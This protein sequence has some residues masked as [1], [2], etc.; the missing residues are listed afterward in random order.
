MSF[1]SSS[2]LDSSRV[3]AAKVKVTLGPFFTLTAMSGS[4]GPSDGAVD[5]DATA[6]TERGEGSSLQPGS[7]SDARSRT[8]PPPAATKVDKSSIAKSEPL[9]SPSITLQES[10]SA[11]TSPYSSLQYAPRQ[12]P[13]VIKRPSQSSLRSH[14]SLWQQQQQASSNGANIES[15]TPT[16]LSAFPSSS[17]SASSPVVSTLAVEGLPSSEDQQGQNNADQ[18]SA[19]ETLA[20]QQLRA[21]AEELGVRVGSLGWAL[22]EQIYSSP[23][24]EWA[25]LGEMLNR[26]EVT[27]LLP[28]S[29][30][31]SSEITLSHAYNHI[32]FST[33]SSSTSEI[34]TSSFKG[35]EKE[36]ESVTL[37]T[38]KGLRADLVDDTD[39]AESV[40]HF[41]S[42]VPREDM[43]FVSQLR[44]ASKRVEL[45]KTL[46][47]LPSTS[48]QSDTP[49]CFKILAHATG[50][51][52]PPSLAR[53]EPRTVRSRSSSSGPF[54]S[55]EQRQANR[56]S[57]TFATLF[58]GRRE[59]KTSAEDNTELKAESSEEA[60]KGDVI[61]VVQPTRMITVAVIDG[62]I[63]RSQ[64]LK[65]IAASTRSS[66]RKPLTPALPNEIID[67]VCS[68]ADMFVPPSA[69]TPHP[70]NGSLS[71]STDTDVSRMGNNVPLLAP[72]L[73]TP[74]QLADIF[75]DFY[76]SVRL[77]LLQ[78]EDAIDIEEALKQIEA[79]IC[80]EVYDRIFCPYASVDMF[81][82]EALTSR[83]SILDQMGVNLQRLGLQLTD[84]GSEKSV[85]VRSGLN[86]VVGQAGAQLQSLGDR[87][88]L[89][90]SDK[91]GVLVSAHKIIVD[92]LAK[93]PKINLIDDVETKLATKEDDKQSEDKAKKEEEKATSSTS[94]ADLIL[95]ILIFCIVKSN[96]SRLAS[97]LFY[98]QRFH[99]EALVRGEASYCLVNVQAAVAFLENVEAASL[100]LAS[101]IKLVTA[102]ELEQQRRKVD[103]DGRSQAQSS[104]PPPMPMRMRT[105]VA[106]DVGE[107]AGMSNRVITGVLGTGLGAFGRMMGAG[108]NYAMGIDAANPGRANGEVPKKQ[109]S[110][111]DVRGFLSGGATAKLGSVLSKVVAMENEGKE[112]VEVKRSRPIIPRTSSTSKTATDYGIENDERRKDLINSSSLPSSSKASISDRLASL[113]LLNRTNTASP[114]PSLHQV[115]PISPANAEKNTTRLPSAAS[116]NGS[117]RLSAYKTSLGPSLN[118]SEALRSPITPASFM[119]QNMLLSPLI[120]TSST[121]DGFP[122]SQRQIPASL[123]SP[124]PPLS[125]PPTR[126][127]PLHIVLASTGSVASIKI[128]LIVESLLSH[129]N[130]RIQIISTKASF[131][132]YNH[133][134]VL[135]AANGATNTD[136]EG[137]TVK[138]LAR[139]MET[140]R[141]SEESKEKCPRL[142][143]WSDEDEWTQW[144]AVG[145]AIL[146]IELRRWADIVLIAPCSANTL[147]KINAGLCDDLL[148]SLLSDV[149]EFYDSHHPLFLFQRQA[150]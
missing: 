67:V 95:P 77:Q 138:D 101:D 17:G 144:N 45:F 82:D 140:A 145:D 25:E 102:A 74:D 68:F 49:P 54:L 37:V 135:A 47:P 149:C 71:V 70:T 56:A 60:R 8:P 20:K 116:M 121:H 61:Q 86:D 35:K 131:Y 128:P 57:V 19:A 52:L 89:S 33:L 124:F 2:L 90:P 100:G 30:L 4:T 107:I 96:P 93:L 109:K 58:G 110:I 98:I 73:Y 146:H 99:P 97:N 123:Q 113:P 12:R 46:S 5:L 78:G 84:D 137:Y 87:H 53:R 43:K 75:Q 91:L 114:T 3:I 28:T 31:K 64:V 129:E 132:F 147:A 59:K 150:S 94:S 112:P 106:Q 18:I 50:L 16:I 42:F 39:P 148:V 38:F 108:T 105:R 13:S 88:C 34:L 79:V 36:R 104:Q 23:S 10:P 72:F 1:H 80:S 7:S 142:H 130:V 62:E 139:E 117:L 127:R 40:M 9:S 81:H 44:T 141:E 27:L 134:A 11:K 41:T 14:S 85:L 92:G 32:I 22:L 126:E 103:T 29:P 55:P 51:L 26:G 119:D 21:D 136:E 65:E 111:E 15:S 118:D 66:I 115:E 24:A 133:E 76:N 125:S 63:R 6:A 120:P 122:F 143:I 69:M 48:R 83:I